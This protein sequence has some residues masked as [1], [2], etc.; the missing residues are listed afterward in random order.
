MSRVP[1]AAVRVLVTGPDIAQASGAGVQMHV[2]YLVQVFEVSESV[3]I[4]PFAATSTKYDEPLLLKVS[5]LLTRWVAFVAHVRSADVVH[6]NSSIDTRSFIRDFGFVALAWAARR[7]VLLQYHGGG[8]H[9]VRWATSGLTRRLVTA[10]LRIPRVTL[11]LSEEQIEPMRDT[12]SIAN[13]RLIR[14]YVP[15]P[16]HVE[17]DSS[18][19]PLRALFMSRLEKSKGVIECI[20]AFAEVSL[21]GAELRIAGSGSLTEQVAQ[22]AAEVPGVHFLGFVQGNDR[23]ALLDWADV[24]LLPSDH[25]EGLPYSVL[26]AAARGCALLTSSRGALATVVLDRVTGI[27]VPARDTHSIASGLR[28]MGSD[29]DLVR[30][31]GVEARQLVQKDFSFESMRDRYG[32]LYREVAG[33]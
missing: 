16:E 31:M 8:T 30:G 14:N 9:R 18:P 10:M 15:V 27:I 11:F 5:R 20:D 29:S 2:R 22:R 13:A 32:S 7:P 1:D 21:E 12:F 28:D 25:D 3:R 19:H 33:R 4:V 26:E 23:D 17:K 24:L 6:I